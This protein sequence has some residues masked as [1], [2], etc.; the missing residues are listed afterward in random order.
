MN[1]VF[2]PNY[3]LFIINYSLE[4]VSYPKIIYNI[5]FPATLIMKLKLVHYPRILLPWFAYG[6]TYIEL[7]PLTWMC[8]IISHHCLKNR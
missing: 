7:I 1:S 8:I 6:N 3:S 5:F 4:R 2:K